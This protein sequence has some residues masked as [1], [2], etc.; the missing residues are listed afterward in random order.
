MRVYPQILK[1]ELILCWRN[2]PHKTS[3]AD[4]GA[5]WTTMG[6]LKLSDKEKVTNEIT[7]VLDHK[8]IKFEEPYNAIKTNFS[9]GKEITEN[10]LTQG[11][12]ELIK[13]LI[14]EKYSTD[15]WNLESEGKEKGACYLR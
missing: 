2:L 13:K 5:L 11:E 1:I 10:K 4:C 9:K 6:V 12:V 3:N 14:K 15:S 7:G 8:E